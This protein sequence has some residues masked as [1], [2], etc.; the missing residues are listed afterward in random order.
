MEGVNLQRAGPLLQNG[1][2]QI[3][4]RLHLDDVGH[5]LHELPQAFVVAHVA[6]ASSG[7]LRS[8][9]RLLVV[10]GGGRG[11]EQKQKDSGGGNG[12]EP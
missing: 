6:F 9:A 11:D 2:V 12:P 3:S 4:V 10:V 7:H 5:V 1:K 8:D